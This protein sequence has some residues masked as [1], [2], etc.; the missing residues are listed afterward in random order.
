MDP[1]ALLFLMTASA[2]NTALP[3]PGIILTFTRS[4]R[5]LAAGAAVSAGLLLSGLLLAT[6]A[7]LI[8]AGLMVI[9][10]DALAAL[11]WIGFAVIL[12]IALRLVLAP[13]AVAA[14][15]PGQASAGDLLAGFAIGITSPFN[16]VF[17]LAILPQFA[18][19]RLGVASAA[20]LVTAYL[21][22]KVAVLT[23]VSVL[24]AAAGHAV[25]GGRR[26]RLFQ[27]LAGAALAG[28]ALTGA[29]MPV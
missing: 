25:L 8:L 23:A 6:A 29:A 16:L 15:G 12:W 26:A 17:L 13:A 2:I 24:G 21:A 5:G 1:S 4:S 19:E 20:A 22:G 3:G 11:R 18:P 27:R 14:T 10:P 28:F 7:V 9:S